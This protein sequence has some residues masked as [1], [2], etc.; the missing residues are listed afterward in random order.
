[1]VEPDAVLEVSDG[2]Y[3]LAVARGGLQFQG[4]PFGRWKPW[5]YLAKRASW[6]G[7]FTRPMSRTGAASGSSW[8]GT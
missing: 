5:L 2:F 4:A 1:M 8:K 3:D 6:P 7:V